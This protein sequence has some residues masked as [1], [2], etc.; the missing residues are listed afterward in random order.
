VTPAISALLNSAA[1]AINGGTAPAKDAENGAFAQVLAGTT[2]DKSALDLAAVRL[3]AKIPGR[4]SQPSTTHIRILPARFPTRDVE[5]AAPKSSADKADGTLQKGA[6]VVRVKSSAAAAENA[7]AL[8]GNV[9]GVMTAD[10]IAKTVAAGDAVN[11]SSQA[12]KDAVRMNT[13]TAKIARDDISGEQGASLD[14]PATMVEVAVKHQAT[15]FA[16]VRARSDHQAAANAPEAI[17]PEDQKISPAVP[18]QIQA[19]TTRS[20]HARRAVGPRV[21]LAAALSDLNVAPVANSV[22]PSIGQQIS[23][24]IANEVAVSPETTAFVEV[25]PTALLSYSAPAL[26]AL[27]LQ[28]SPAMLGPVTLVLSGSG[29][30]L[31]IRLDAERA[32]T[33]GMV[34]QGR[35]EILSR[36]T[37]A[38]YSIEEL[39][40]GQASDPVRTTV[41]DP[42]SQVT[43]HVQSNMP[44]GAHAGGGGSQQ[45][46]EQRNQ[47]REIIRRPESTLDPAPDHQPSPMTASSWP[48]V[49]GSR[50]FRSI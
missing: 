7:M 28:L 38:G 29:S 46:F 15:H 41:I 33:A 48:R 34:E 50:F 1:C 9:P 49:A 11:G 6:K 24:S 37:V 2:A 25:T 40:I 27:T 39:L 44:G 45:L 36:L 18:S 42:S 47:D 26:R 17:Q 20:D 8:L 4:A 32:D 16:P 14:V 13:V 3:D 22:A 10:P 43:S 19:E 35:D 12:V 5:E 30:S 21:G 31:R 23:A